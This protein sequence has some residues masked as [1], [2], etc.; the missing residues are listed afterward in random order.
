MQ[1][2]PSPGHE[3]LDV[4]TYHTCNRWCD[5]ARQAEV[6]RLRITASGP[7]GWRWCLKRV[8]QSPGGA[9]VRFVDSSQP[10]AH[11]LA[12][13]RLRPPYRGDL[14]NGDKAINQRPRLVDPR[15]L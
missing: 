3:C 11:S 2:I 10:S 9:G 13:R 12:P 7:L 6:R 4:T 1:Q 15:D 8:S 14:A 5:E